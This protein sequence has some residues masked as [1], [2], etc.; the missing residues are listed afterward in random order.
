MGEIVKYRSIC[1]ISVFEKLLEHLI[2][3]RVVDE[4]E[5]KSGISENQF[6]FRK[7]RSTV[8]VIRKV[9]GNISMKWFQTLDRV[10]AMEFEPGKN[11]ALPGCTSNLVS[12][13][14]SPLKER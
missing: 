2:R 5:S 4:L 13:R 7:G 14:I 11:P 10:E 12:M 3:K 8:D 9:L 1:M 6:E